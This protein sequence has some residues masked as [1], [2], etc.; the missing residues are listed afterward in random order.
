MVYYNLILLLYYNTYTIV[1]YNSY[2][3]AVAPAAAAEEPA[4]NRFGFPRTEG[5]VSTQPGQAPA[6]ARG[7]SIA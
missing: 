7:R 6:V 2:S 5:S 3:E 4:K 1:D